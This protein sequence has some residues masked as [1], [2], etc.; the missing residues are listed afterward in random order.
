MDKDNSDYWKLR[1]LYKD[2]EDD[3]PRF[4]PTNVVEPLTAR[5]LFQLYINTFLFVSTLQANIYLQTF[6][7]R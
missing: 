6:H 3:V 5:N 7:T 2:E 4:P 1:S